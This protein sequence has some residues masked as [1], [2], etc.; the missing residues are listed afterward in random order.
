MIGHRDRLT[1][2]MRLRH[3]ALATFLGHAFTTIALRRSHGVRLHRACHDRRRKQPERQQRDTDF[4]N[5]L[6]VLEQIIETA[7]FRRKTLPLPY[8]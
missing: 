1:A 4:A 8:T 3:L 5:G 7:L 2:G 6:H